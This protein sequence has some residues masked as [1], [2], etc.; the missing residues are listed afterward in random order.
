MIMK[1]VDR[2]AAPNPCLTLSR[3]SGHFFVAIPSGP[4]PTCA[5][6][7]QFSKKALGL[8]MSFGMSW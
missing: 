6:P 7:A 2:L 4:G 5:F 1:R 3:P 8:G